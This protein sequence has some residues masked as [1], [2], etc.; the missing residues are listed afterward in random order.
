MLSVRMTIVIV[1]DVE[2]EQCSQKG[3]GVSNNATFLMSFQHNSAAQ[4]TCHTTIKGLPL[5][6][7]GINSNES[8]IN[9]KAAT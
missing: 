7:G 2:D 6:F 5:K 1:K 9:D 4:E 8:L 3:H